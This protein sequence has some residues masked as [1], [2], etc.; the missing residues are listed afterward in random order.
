MLASNCYNIKPNEEII[1]ILHGTGYKF[2]DENIYCLK[3]DVDEN[4]NTYFYTPLTDVYQICLL[5]KKCFRHLYY[6]CWI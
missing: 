1:V 5:L 4:N 2:S 6:L 3:Q